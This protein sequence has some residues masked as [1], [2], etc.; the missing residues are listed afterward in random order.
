MLGAPRITRV[1]ASREDAAP[2]AD[3][4]GIVLPKFH[5]SKGRIKR[6]GKSVLIGKAIGVLHGRGDA[7]AAFISYAEDDAANRDFCRAV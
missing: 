5:G 4:D 6:L 7:T 3:F 2:L 1:A